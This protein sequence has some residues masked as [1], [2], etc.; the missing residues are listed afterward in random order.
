MT[1]IKI[2]VVKY[3]SMWDVRADVDFGVHGYEEIVRYRW[4]YQAELVARWW[5]RRFAKEYDTPVELI[6]K[7]RIGQ[8]RDKDTHGYDPEKIVG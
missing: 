3:H 7:N 2:E 4:K 1:S 5:A 8:I 6:I